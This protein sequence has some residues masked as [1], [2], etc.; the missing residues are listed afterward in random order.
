[1]SWSTFAPWQTQDQ[2]EDEKPTPSQ[3][4]DVNESDIVSPLISS[5]GQ[6]L[7]KTA[8]AVLPSFNFFGSKPE[9]QRDEPWQLHHHENIVEQCGADE[10]DHAPVHN[11]DLL[12]TESL[13]SALSQEPQLPELHHCDFAY[14]VMAGAPGKEQ[15]RRRMLLSFHADTNVMSKDAHQRLG[16]NIMPYRG[17]PVPVLG[18]QDSIPVG[19]AEVQWSFCGRSK[20]Y[21]T[22]FYVVEDVEYDLLIGRPSMRQQE[23]YRVDPAIAKRLRESYQCQ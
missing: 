1:M 5:C 17:A 8:S 21:R 12:L 10:N 18:L 23:L 13:D 11:D 4:S 2:N 15:L 22:A 3:S 7:Y 9:Q 19:I 14:D 16:T 20:P 6:L